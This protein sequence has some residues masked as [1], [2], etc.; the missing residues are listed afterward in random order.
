MLLNLSNHPL[1]NWSDLQIKT[2]NELYGNIVD[3]DF[4]QIPPEADEKLVAAL[5]EDYKDICVDILSS[6]KDINNAI[7]IMGEMTFIFHLVT[8]LKKLNIRCIASTTS[9]D[10][11]Q[12]GSEKTSVF[13]FV[14]FRDY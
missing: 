13:N 1:A 11:K 3:L 5:V 4:P 6:S 8:V 14:S 7:H 10:T 2:A 9:R 12:N